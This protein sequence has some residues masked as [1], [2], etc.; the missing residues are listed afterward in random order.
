MEDGKFFLSQ[1]YNLRMKKIQLISILQ[2]RVPGHSGIPEVLPWSNT[3]EYCLEAV[4]G[5]TGH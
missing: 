5:C 3:L 2:A 4:E 1:Y